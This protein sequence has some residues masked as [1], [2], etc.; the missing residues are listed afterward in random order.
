ME[1]LTLKFDDTIFR[2]MK[3]RKNAY[4]KRENLKELD[5][6]KFIELCV[7]CNGSLV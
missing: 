1:E 6:N 3:Q 2:I 7:L 5:W 4:M